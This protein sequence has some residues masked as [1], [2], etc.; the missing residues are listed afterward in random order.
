LKG[1]VFTEDVIEAWISYKREE[2]ID[3]LR[4]PA[5]PCVRHVLRHGLS[6]SVSCLGGRGSIRIHALLLLYDEARSV[7]PSSG[8]THIPIL[9]PRIEDGRL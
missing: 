5:S 7:A 2:E 4:L 8:P 3:L 1:D 6:Q 9:I